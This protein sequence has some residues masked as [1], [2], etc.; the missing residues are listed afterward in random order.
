MVAVLIRHNTTPYIALVRRIP[1]VIVA[2]GASQLIDHLCGMKPPLQVVSASM[3]LVLVLS[4]VLGTRAGR[5]PLFTVLDNACTGGKE[6][7]IFVCVQVR[8]SLKPGLPRLSYGREKRLQ[9]RDLRIC[10]IFRSRSTRV[11][12]LQLSRLK[13]QKLAETWLNPEV[14]ASM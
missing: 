3:D 10:I 9:A 11:P 6:H 8:A 7:D 5:G 14:T 13:K 2:T 12:P 4:A 1:L